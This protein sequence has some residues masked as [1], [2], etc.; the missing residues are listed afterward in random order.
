[1]NEKYITV[2]IKYPE[3]EKYLSNLDTLSKY[4]FSES[5]YDIIYNKFHDLALNI[6]AL[7]A[8]LDTNFNGFKLFRV[9]AANT[10][11]EFEDKTIIQT[12]SFPPANI[13]KYSGRAN[14]KNKSVFY[15]TDNLVP[16]LRESNIEINEEAYL[17]IWNYNSKRN[18]TYVCCLPEKLPKNN[19]WQ[20][21]GKYHHNFLIEK[22]NNDDT[23]LLKYKVALRNFITDKFMKENYPYS[24]TSMLS[25][26][27]LYKS[28]FDMIMYPIAKTFQDYT[29]FAIHPNVVLNHLNLEIVFQ[30]VI[31]DINDQHTKFKVKSIGHLE[32]DKIYWR[33]PD[34][35]IVEKYLQAKK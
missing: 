26:E 11:N 24:I 10:I 15:C 20:E 29:N 16:A 6:P 12:F 34:D 19:S 9:R 22:Q 7:G 31:T 21:Y 5:D 3:F 4:D 35:E 17:S 28:G 1:M 13:C 14:I 2:D 30:I 27:Y 8:S 32:D 18:L 23:N 25:N 33:K